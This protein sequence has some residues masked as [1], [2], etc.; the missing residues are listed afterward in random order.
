[1][2]HL[3]V[4]ILKLLLAGGFAGGTLFKNVVRLAN[5]LEFGFFFGSIISWL[6]ILKVVGVIVLRRHF[7]LSPSSAIMNYYYRLYK[8]HT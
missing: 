1:M 6:R 8:L 3:P 2:N 4:K 7:Y 5:C